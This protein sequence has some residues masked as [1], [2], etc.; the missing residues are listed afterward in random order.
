MLILVWEASDRLCGKRLKALIPSLLAAIE[1]H[2]H[3]DLDTCVKDKL[4]TMSAASIDR[5]L[6]PTRTK[7]S[8]SGRRRQGSGNTFKRQIPVRTFSDWNDPAPGFMEVDLV[9]HCGGVKQDGNFVHSLVMT[10]IASGWTECLSMQ[11]RNQLL[12]VEGIA[13][14][15]SVL[16]FKIEGIDT[17]NGS[18]FINEVVFTY[19]KGMGYEQTRSRLYRKNDQAWV[20]Q[21]NGSIVRRMV[22]YNKLS[23]SQACKA[24]QQLYDSSR[25]FVNY[26][27]PSFKLKSKHRQGAHVQKKYHSPQTPCERLL[28][29]EDVDDQSKKALRLQLSTLDPVK[30]LKLIRQSQEKLADLSNSTNCESEGTSETVDLTD[31]MK[32]LSQAWKVGEV[33]PTHREKVKTQRT[34]RTRIDPFEADWQMIEHWMEFDSSTTAKEVMKRLVEIDADK[35]SQ[36]SQLRTLQRRTKEWRTEKA[37]QL[38]FGPSA[39]QAEEDSLSPELGKNPVSSQ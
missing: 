4:I 13:K 25:L 2:G 31:F 34:W 12:V 14:A 8:S 29:R 9:E 15:Q 6:K 22:G 5:S 28:A 21:K 7:I 37:N 36:K 26:F 27:Q 10:D 3:I 23:G 1:R 30:L 39:Q 19:S 24:L 18:E 11:V 32:S 16:P 35:Y 33:R 20:V 38:I 17:D